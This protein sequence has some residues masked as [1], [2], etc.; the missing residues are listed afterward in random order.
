MSKLKLLLVISHWGNHHGIV[1]VSV[2]SVYSFDFTIG[3]ILCRVYILWLSVPWPGCST[4]QILLDH[5]PLWTKL[6]TLCFPAFVRP[7][8]LMLDHSPSPS[9]PPPPTKNR[10]RI[11]HVRQDPAPR[12]LCPR[13][14]R[15][16]ARG[17]GRVG[18]VHRHGDGGQQLRVAQP[19]ARLH[20]PA[21]HAQEGLQV[22]R[23]Q[24]VHDLPGIILGV[25]A[26]PQCLAELGTFD[27]FE[28]FQ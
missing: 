14:V 11:H 19:R 18:G 5:V 7:A 25:R 22:W 23:P 6:W 9:H 24:V 4:R 16:Q 28:F 13:E 1:L 12:Q 3:T 2:F 26:V 8:K 17:G 21:G 27:I 20:L 10:D 15:A